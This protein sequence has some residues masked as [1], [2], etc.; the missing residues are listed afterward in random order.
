MDFRQLY[1]EGDGSSSLGRCLHG[2]D[3]RGSPDGRRVFNTEWR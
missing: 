1:P 3:E 2:V